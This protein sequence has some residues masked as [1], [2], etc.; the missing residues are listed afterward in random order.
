MPRQQVRVYAV[1]RRATDARVSGGDST[2]PGVAASRHS[3]DVIVGPATGVE[4]L[5]QAI[6]RCQQDLDAAGAGAN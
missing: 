5:P 1:S 3:G 6:L 2:S 4:F